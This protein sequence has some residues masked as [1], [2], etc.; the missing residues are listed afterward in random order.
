MAQQQQ[1]QQEDEA[2]EEEKEEEELPRED[3]G[4]EF[5][6]IWLGVEGMMH[7]NC[8]M[9]AEELAQSKLGPHPQSS[10]APLGKL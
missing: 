1:Q 10:A 6:Q 3:L 2:E 8:T 7:K 4:V 5:R 9:Q